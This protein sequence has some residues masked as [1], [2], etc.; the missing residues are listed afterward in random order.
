MIENLSKLLLKDYGYELESHKVCY[1]HIKKSKIILPAIILFLAITVL[2]FMTEFVDF[3]ILGFAFFILVLI[4]LALR[5][6]ETYDVVVIT[7]EFLIQQY[8]KDEVIAIN[9]DKIT[10]FGTDKTGVVIK[11]SKN[12]ISLD[13]AI[14]ADD[15]LVLIEILEA[16][17]KTFD[18]TKDYMIRPIEIII[19]NNDIIHFRLKIC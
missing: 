14:L 11:D 4:P 17:G 9:F 12:T 8:R 10:K 19:K 16:K 2:F 5:K 13:P 18:K 15:I 3:V 7:P 6:G 1:E